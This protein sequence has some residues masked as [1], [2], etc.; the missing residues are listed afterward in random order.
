MNQ[1]YLNAID[2]GDRASHITQGRALHWG[3]VSALLSIEQP[4]TFTTDLLDRVVSMYAGGVVTASATNGNDQ[5]VIADY[6]W[7]AGSS[8][9]PFVGF[10]GSHLY[11]GLTEEGYPNFNIASTRS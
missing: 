4:E 2:R 3:I 10:E 1:L 5:L 7:W 6:S 11:F 8:P 9:A